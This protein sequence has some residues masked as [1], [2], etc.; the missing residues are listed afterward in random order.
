MKDSCLKASN[1]R[2]LPIFCSILFLSL[3][4]YKAQAQGCCSG[5]SGSPVAGGTS[6]GILV[7]HQ[8][9]VSTNFQ[10]INT[11]KFLNGTKD[12]SSFL[13]NYNS[14]Y[15]Y[16]RL[17][18]GVSKSLT[19]S[20]ETGYFFKKSQ[21][22]LHH[23]DIQN[24]AG[25]GDLILFPR[26]DVYS[27]N[28]EKSRNEIT[29]GLGMKIPVGKY[30]DSFVTY[31]NPRTGKK[32]YTPMAPAVMPTTGSQ[33]YIFYLFGFRGYPTHNFRIFTSML[34]VRKGWNPLG[35]KFGDFAS[36]GLFAGKTFFRKLGVT[37]QIKGEW[38][39]GMKSAKYIDPRVYYNLDA[40]STGG[41]KIMFVPQVNYSY[42]T[43]SFYALTEVPLYQYVNG[44]AIASQ[45]QLTCG[46]AYRF[47]VPSKN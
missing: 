16:T 34:Y 18:Y 35:E 45:Y 24:C 46:F 20:V 23:S 12:T 40:S 3:P 28:T 25:F 4:V 39:D 5:G 44:T 9:E 6:Q 13:D 1:W 8:F 27:H 21:T 42:K 30:L 10:Y 2:A 33:D 19:M 17:A 14:E 15:L 47:M 36:V 31:T 32:Y 7:D 43:W 41:K 37:V 22:G 11:N 29:A 38:V 26:Y